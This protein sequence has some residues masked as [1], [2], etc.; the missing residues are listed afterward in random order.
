[1]ETLPFKPYKGEAVRDIVIDDP[2]YLHWLVKNVNLDLYA[3]LADDIKIQ[4]F[5]HVSR[6]ESGN[7]ND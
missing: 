7:I 2:A 4:L 3:G 1:M 5:R 6:I